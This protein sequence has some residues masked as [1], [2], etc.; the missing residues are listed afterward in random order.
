MWLSNLLNTQCSLWISLSTS[1]SMTWIERKEPQKWIF[2]YYSSELYSSSDKIQN[3]KEKDIEKVNCRFGAITSSYIFNL[4]LLGL[5]KVTHILPTAC[6]LPEY[7][8]SDSSPWSL[9]FNVIFH[10]VCS[11]PPPLILCLSIL[12]ISFFIFPPFHNSI[13]SKWAVICCQFIMVSS[14]PAYVGHKTDFQKIFV[15]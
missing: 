4:Q 5:I 11:S 1:T 3:Y 2:N 10:K 9:S 8:P 6:L 13:I 14:S 15:E 12:F 7:F